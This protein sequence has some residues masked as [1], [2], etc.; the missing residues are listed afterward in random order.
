MRAAQGQRGEVKPRIT[1]PGRCGGWR[2]L[3]G[4]RCGH[5]LEAFQQ[6]PSSRTG[7]GA[8]GS[9]QSCDQDGKVQDAKDSFEDRKGTCLRRDRGNPSS[10]ERSHGAETVVDEIEAFGNAMKV[11]ARIQIKGVWLE[12]G[13]HSVDAGKSEAHQ[14]INA[15][16][17]KDGFRC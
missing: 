16:G 17:S 2:H 7:L 13:H 12:R 10:A 8:V 14:Q 3:C 9:Y 5:P 15:E 11:S 4:P 6:T 1:K